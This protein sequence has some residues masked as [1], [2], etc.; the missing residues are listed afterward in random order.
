MFYGLNKGIDSHEYVV[1]A[2]SH[3]A[4][5]TSLSV[6]A[7]GAVAHQHFDVLF[8]PAKYNLIAS[9]AALPKTAMSLLV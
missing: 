4:V 9:T 7:F 3:F 8:I 1:V 2:F 6:R 5:P